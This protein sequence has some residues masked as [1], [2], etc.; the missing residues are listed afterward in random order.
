MLKNEGKEFRLIMLG[1][2]A[3]ENAIKR[4]FV[5]AGFSI[6]LFGQEKY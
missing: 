6:M 3:D 1:F 2:G 4:K 5:N